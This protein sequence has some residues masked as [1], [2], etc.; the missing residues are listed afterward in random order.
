MSEKN[1]KLNELLT[2]DPGQDERIRAA[3]ALGLQQKVEF[4]KK[5]HTMNL[6]MTLWSRVIRTLIR[7][8][9]VPD[10]TTAA[11]LFDIPRD[12][13]KALENIVWNNKKKPCDEKK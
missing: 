12:M 3:Y 4:E 7:N 11:N 6:Q 13:R 8:K 10:F 2:G 1:E 9:L 5:H